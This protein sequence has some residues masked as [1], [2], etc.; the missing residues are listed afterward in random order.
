[1][2]LGAERSKDKI[3]GVGGA[4]STSGA[5]GPT[6]LPSRANLLPG[7]SPGQLV[8]DVSKS[9]QLGHCG[10]GSQVPH[11]QRQEPSR[12]TPVVHWPARLGVAATT[13]SS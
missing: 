2:R 6:L 3:K 1:M 5:W 12:P 13:G 8:C 11:R 10:A 4:P 9:E 7:P